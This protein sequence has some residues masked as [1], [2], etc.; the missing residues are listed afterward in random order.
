[1]GRNGLYKR[2]QVSLKGGIEVIRDDTTRV[3][4]TGVWNTSYFPGGQVLLAERTAA[5]S[6]GGDLICVTHDEDTLLA[7]L[8][9]ISH[10]G[11]QWSK[12]QLTLLRFHLRPGKVD[13][14][15]PDAGVAQR[16]R[17]IC[18][19]AARRKI[20]VGR[21]GPVLSC[22]CGR[23]DSGRASRGDQTQEGN[24]AKQRR[25]FHAV[26]N[27]ETI[28]QPL[29]QLPFRS[30]DRLSVQ[31]RR[32]DSMNIPRFVSLRVIEQSFSVIPPA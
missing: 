20:D 21:G 32:V 10:F 2:L 17:V 6:V 4:I 8:R 1:M 26:T 12:V 9:P 18:S 23:R 3:A 25:E 27:R 11:I 31:H 15:S 28:A 30:E 5:R 16:C 24:A 7:D 19:I 14:D 13:I 22:S 29:T